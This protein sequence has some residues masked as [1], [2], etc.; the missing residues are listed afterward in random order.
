LLELEQQLA[1]TA[2]IA[3]ASIPPDMI[4]QLEAN[5]R[6]VAEAG[7]VLAAGATHIR[8]EGD[9][10]GL[11]IDDQA[12]ALGERN[13][14]RPIIIRLGGAELT[15]T[16]PAGAASAQQALD[17]ALARHEA[18]LRELGVHDLAAARARADAAR[19][20][21]GEL[22]TLEAQIDAV[23]P[24]DDALG[25]AEGRD[26]LKLFV[27]NL[28]EIKDSA[29]GA[30]PDLDA[31][32]QAVEAAD[33]ATARAEGVQA[34]A[35]DALRRLEQEEAP[36]ATA[37]AGAA[38][39]L[40]NACAQLATIEARPEFAALPAD[41]EQA[42]IGAAAA[43][44]RLSEAERDA[45]AHDLA[46]IRRRID[47]IDA[48]AQGAAE[49]RTRLIT[50]IARLE[51]VV[52]S[53]GG[54]GL[55]DHAA[56]AGEEVEA[57]QAA[58]QRITEEADTLKLLRDTLDQARNETSARFVGPVARR[59]RRHIE[60]LLPGCDLS[61]SEDLALDAIIRGGFSEN[62]RDL[63]RGT[64]EQLSVLTRIAFA[65]MLLE[66]GRPVS[67]I[68]DDPLVYS[69]DA[70]LD[71]MA[72]ILGD[73]AQRMQVILLTCRDRAFRHLPG[74]RLSLTRQPADRLI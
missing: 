61:F 18:A 73:A 66:Q 24:A 1:E 6:A 42:Q 54:K 47:T 7:A 3:A 63:S 65:D 9:L 67:L 20:A 12:A 53:E 58:L 40:A 41:L 2:K 55:A 71:L 64:Q 49:A 59:A 52:E 19:E 37:E 31:L 15:V 46:A 25:L 48:R 74:H 62:C 50:D 30:P 39:D 32:L 44:V 34:S 8:L 36:M 28:P 43:A 56:A 68:L 57:A 72:E 4:A 13:L 14:I 5:G 27:A 35:L 33:T 21:S 29:E 11:T 51:G 70:R 22:R 26:A 23:T 16:P 69:D 17:L 38:S 45:T 10:T 60:R